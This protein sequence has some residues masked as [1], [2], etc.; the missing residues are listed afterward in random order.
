MNE[1]KAYCSWHFAALNEWGVCP[2]CRKQ[3][4]S[5]LTKALDKTIIEAAKEK[6]DIVVSEEQ[7]ENFWQG[8]PMGILE[9]E[10][11]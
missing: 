10:E 7:L 8:K 3:E 5:K 2:E 11:E 4:L 9:E 1:A 6:Q